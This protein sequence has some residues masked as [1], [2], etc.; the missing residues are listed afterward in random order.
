[1]LLCFWTPLRSH[2][3]S[4]CRYRYE[5]AGINSFE[6]PDQYE[7]LIETHLHKQIRKPLLEHLADE[8]KGAGLR[9]RLKGSS[10]RGLEA[11]DV[12]YARVFLGPQTGH[13]GHQGCP[14]SLG[15]EG[16]RLS[17]RLW[18]QRWAQV[19]YEKIGDAQRARTTRWQAE[20]L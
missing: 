8:A 20:D 4:I 12:E 2:G 19:I 18:P 15:R 9:R 3:L 13:W 10:Y 16:L 1:L 7:T 11:F 5:K 6:I 14:S 17:P